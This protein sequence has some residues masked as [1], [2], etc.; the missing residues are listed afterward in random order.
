MRSTMSN[1]CSLP[2]TPLMLALIFS[3]VLRPYG[4]SHPRIAQSSPCLIDDKAAK[5]NA[6]LVIVFLYQ[7]LFLI[8][9]LP[10]D[11][12]LPVLLFF[13]ISCILIHL[14]VPPAVSP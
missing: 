11:L 2:P 3:Y 7:I 13:V 10:I 9:L 5:F 1:C 12:W 6:M 8:V 14:L 4:Y